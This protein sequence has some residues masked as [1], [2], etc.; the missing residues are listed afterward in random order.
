MEPR[1]LKLNFEKVEKVDTSRNKVFLFFT[2]EKFY[3]E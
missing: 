2:K 3:Q 1:Q